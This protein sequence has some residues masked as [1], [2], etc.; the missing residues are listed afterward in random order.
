MY[1]AEH[2]VGLVMAFLAILLMAI[3]LMRGFGIFGAEGAAVVPSDLVGDPDEPHWL[4]GSLWL[5]AGL[6]A[7]FLSMALHKSDHHLLRDPE[8]L[9]DKDESLWKSEHFTAWAAALA[10]IVLA[11]V[12]ILVGL[13]EFGRGTTAQEGML[14]LFASIIMS[15]V[16][17]TLHSVRHH[18]VAG[19]EEYIVRMVEERAGMTTTTPASTG[20]VVERD[21]GTL[22]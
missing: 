9:D 10:T 2:W 7:A 17:N 5:L 14:W 4:L 16:T 6:S 18:Q 12:G 15:I 21:R 3:G 13:D 1:D 8:L 11:A 22:G 20:T 19:E